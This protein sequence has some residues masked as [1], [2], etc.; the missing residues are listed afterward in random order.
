[1]N[2]IVAEQEQGFH[3]E[4]V[5]LAAPG[6]RRDAEPLR[7]VHLSDLHLARLRARHERLVAR[8]NEWEPDVICLTGDLV[9]RRRS[10]WDLLRGLAGHLRAAYGVFACPGNWE[11]KTRLRYETMRR[12]GDD[13]GVAFLVN[14]SRALQTDAG[15]VYLCGV[16]DL[17]LGWPLWEDA[18]EGNREADYTILMS[19]APLAARLVTPQM[20]VDLVL[21]GHTHGGQMRVPFLW[22]LFLPSA[23][24]GLVGGLYP[25]DWGAAYVNRGFG[26]APRL[27]LR[28]MCPPEVAFF[29]LEGECA[30]S[31]ERGM[32]G[33]L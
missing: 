5:T 23:H 22:R 16:D 18:L 25:M 4:R 7:I 17:A 2:G 31:R 14:E 3:I 1:V 33:P 6:L 20:G 30:R 21:S 13:C 8:V 29:T 15:L 24:G 26:A 28:F 32:P 12:V 27:P 9:T 19:H 11:V 10:S